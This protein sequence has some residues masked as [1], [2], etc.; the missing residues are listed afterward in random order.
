MT[1][2]GQ[3]V[4]CVSGETLFSRAP[5]VPY[6]YRDLVP[7]SK[8]RYRANEVEI[9]SESDVYLLHPPAPPTTQNSAGN[10][11]ATTTT[12]AEARFHCKAAA[13]RLLGLRPRARV[14]FPCP[15]TGV[16]LVNTSP[17]DRCV[18]FHETAALRR[19]CRTR[20]DLPPPPRWCSTDGQGLFDVMTVLEGEGG[21]VAGRSGS[22]GGHAGMVGTTENSLLDVV[23][24]PELS[25]LLGLV[26]GRAEVCVPRSRCVLSL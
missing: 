25:V 24:L 18:R 21:G 20:L 19:I 16:F 15:G 11:T 3:S 8:Q 12:P 1:N 5:F 10:H 13:R 26:G 22:S 17:G 4:P 14:L 9:L 2:L 7:I 23:F 6:L